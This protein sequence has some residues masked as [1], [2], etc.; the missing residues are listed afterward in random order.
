MA[1]LFYSTVRRHIGSILFF[2]I[3]FFVLSW[4][5]DSPLLT[6]VVGLAGVSPIV[7]AILSEE[8]ITLRNVYFSIINK[9]VVFVFSILLFVFVIA[10]FATSPVSLF[11]VRGGT[12]IAFSFFYATLF[13][14]VAGKLVFVATG[15]KGVKLSLGDVLIV[16]L[17]VMA[18][19]GAEIIVELIGYDTPLVAMACLAFQ[20][21]VF[22]A[23]FVVQAVVVLRRN[24]LAESDVQ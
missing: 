24:S 7:V 4:I 14:L 16:A 10:S 23:V 8:R 21:L 11:D 3:V 20:C 18:L 15:K 22:T 6:N 19:G 17:C 13:R 5:S 9:G 12:V 1:L 2:Y